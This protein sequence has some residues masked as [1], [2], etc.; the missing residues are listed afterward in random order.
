MHALYIVKNSFRIFPN[1][2]LYTNEVHISFII[3][4]KYYHL[5]Y[6]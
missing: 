5:N 1:L 6:P 4:Q 2:K 3:L